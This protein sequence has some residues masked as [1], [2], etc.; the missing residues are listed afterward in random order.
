[1][2]P[3]GS[4]RAFMTTDLVGSRIGVGQRIKPISS[5]H[6][7]KPGACP[8]IQWLKNKQTFELCCLVRKLRIRTTYSSLNTD[9][10]N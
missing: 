6:S 2:I 1:M 9:K 4:I 8:L 7:D 5:E 3:A 10:I